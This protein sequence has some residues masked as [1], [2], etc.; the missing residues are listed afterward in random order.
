MCIHTHAQN[1]FGLRAQGEQGIRICFT[2][3][4][5]D[6]FHKGKTWGLKPQK[7]MITQI[8]WP[9]KVD[10]ICIAP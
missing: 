3:G 10:L 6:T 7:Q 1:H 8:F 9:V 4:N 2:E 5:A